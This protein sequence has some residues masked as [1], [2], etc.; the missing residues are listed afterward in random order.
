MRALCAALLLLLLHAAACSK[1]PPDPAADAAAARTLVGGSPTSSTTAGSQDGSSGGAVW[2]GTYTSAPGTLYIPS[3]WSSVHW[4]PPPTSAGIGTGTLVIAIDSATHRL[5]GTVGGPLGPA[6][7]S[8]KVSA[9]SVTASVVRKDPA[10]R[11]FAG[12]LVGTI[13]SDRIDGTLN[14]SLGEASAVRR[15]TFSLSRGDDGGRLQ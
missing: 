8:G 14:V 5:Q 2:Q 1:S 11:G 10:D 9:E 13:T 7:V 15:A 4:S 12:T 3:D 6:I